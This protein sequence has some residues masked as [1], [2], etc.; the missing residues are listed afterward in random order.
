M[1]KT[2][3]LMRLARFQISG[4]F[5]GSWR[6]SPPPFDLHVTV[7]Y[8]LRHTLFGPIFVWSDKVKSDCEFK[9]LFESSVFLKS[10]SSSMPRK[11]KRFEFWYTEVNWLYVKMFSSVWETIYIINNPFTYIGSGSPAEIPIRSNPETQTSPIQLSEARTMA[12]IFLTIQTQKLI[13]WKYCINAYNTLY[14][15]L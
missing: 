8:Y 1:S 2:V 11:A 4:E 9:C 12:N 6:S 7:W 15:F 3:L 13:K 5:I 14:L 10:M